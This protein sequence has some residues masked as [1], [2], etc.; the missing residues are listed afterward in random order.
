M[1]DAIKNRGKSLFLQKTCREK[2]D[3]TPL[4]E[5]RL[6]AL[7]SAFEDQ[8]SV[9]AT[10]GC[11]AAARMANAI[12]ETVFNTD[13][14]LDES[15]GI[16]L[17]QTTM[18]VYEQLGSTK[19]ETFRTESTSADEVAK[20]QGR[21][22][23]NDLDKS[24]LENI[25]AQRAWEALQAIK[26]NDEPEYEDLQNNFNLVVDVKKDAL[27]T[28]GNRIRGYIPADY[29]TVE[30]GNILINLG[31]GGNSGDD[32]DN[33]AIRG[34]VSF[35][36][37]GTIK[38]IQCPVCVKKVIISTFS[39]TSLMTGDTPLVGTSLYNAGMDRM[40][41]FDCD[42]EFDVELTLDH[43]TPTGYGFWY[44][45]EDSDVNDLPNGFGPDVL[46]VS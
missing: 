41:C 6:I 25:D 29:D 7:T 3:L 21:Q 13:S 5:A 43:Q 12:I 2:F 8:V 26:S 45:V 36:A 10:D 19:K 37:D 9:M 27:S 33:E 4:Q 40:G 22:I 24:R 32:N 1:I 42:T 44:G 34:I 20:K 31:D 38:S 35:N 23:K 39:N 14:A 28:E 16:A 30:N 46:I 17:V 18:Q 11:F 15:N